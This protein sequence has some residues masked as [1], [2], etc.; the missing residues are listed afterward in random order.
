MATHL[1]DLEV[2]NHNTQYVSGKGNGTGAGTIA[3]SH[4]FRFVNWED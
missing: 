3:S 1:A 4:S 2:D